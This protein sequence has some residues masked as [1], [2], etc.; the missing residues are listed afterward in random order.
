M[1][2]THRWKLSSVGGANET[3]REIQIEQQNE[4][5]GE[6]IKIQNFCHVSNAIYALRDRTRFAPRL[7][8]TE[9]P[10]LTL[11]HT[12]AKYTHDT[13]ILMYVS[14]R[15]ETYKHTTRHVGNIA[16]CQTASE[17]E[18][19]RALERESKRKRLCAVSENCKFWFCFQ[20]TTLFHTIELQYNLRN[21]FKK[22]DF[23]METLRITSNHYIYSHNHL[24]SFR[25]FC[26]IKAQHS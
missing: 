7:T 5:N 23:A 12:C 14:R 19:G 20:L 21:S 11:T 13:Q 1:R 25:I 24:H 22:H 26:T 17:T 3:N 18:T 6:N 16:K 15:Q 8:H 2:H 9:S 4:H 10:T